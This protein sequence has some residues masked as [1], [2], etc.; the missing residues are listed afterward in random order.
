MYFVTPAAPGP[1]VES[2]RVWTLQS[3]SQTEFDQPNDCFSIGQQV[4]AA[5][6]PVATMTVRAWCLCPNVQDQVCESQAKK[7]TQK[8]FTPN[9]A[10]PTKQP[11]LVPVPAP[12]KQ[13]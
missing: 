6:E 8:M 9:F 2:K 11:L 12:G 10:T 4:L 3:T 13:L 1:K 5:I 7:T